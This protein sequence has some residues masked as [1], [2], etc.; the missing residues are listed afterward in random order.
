MGLNQK[1]VVL[2]GFTLS[3]ENDLKCIFGSK[4]NNLNKCEINFKYLIVLCQEKFQMTKTEF[5]ACPRWKQID[6]KKEVGL[7]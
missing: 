6:M 5:V 2:P 4:R 7:F 3:F 1:Y